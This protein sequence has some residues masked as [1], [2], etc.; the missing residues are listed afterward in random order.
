MS[1]LIIIDG[2]KVN[3]IVRQPRSASTIHTRGTMLEYFCMQ[4]VIVINR[5]VPWG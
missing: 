5:D 4:A 3:I 1:I 2:D